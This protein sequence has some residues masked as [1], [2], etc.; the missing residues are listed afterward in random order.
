VAQPGAAQGQ[1]G[2]A[3]AGLGRAA[4]AVYTPTNYYRDCGPLP[5]NGI[6]CLREH[7]QGIIS[8]GITGS[9]G[10]VTT[11]YTHIRYAMADSV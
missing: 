1:G 10:Y 2:A 3:P 11:I 7:A 8:G 6:I 9:S 5:T 4:G